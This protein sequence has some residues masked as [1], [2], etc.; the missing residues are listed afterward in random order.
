MQIQNPTLFDIAALPLIGPQGQI[1]F[2]VILKGTFLQSTGAPAEPQMRIAYGDELANETGAVRYESDIV[3]FKP[4]TDVVLW[5][6][7]YAP[8]GKPAPSVPVSAGIGAVENQLMVFGERYWNHT[9]LL[10]REYRITA[11]KPF[12]RQPIVYEAAFGGI[13]MLSGAYCAENL[14]GC[15]FHDPKGKQNLAG[16]PLPRIE[17][18]RHLIRAVSDHPR[19]V[20]F[21]FYHRACQPRAAFAGTYDE[22]WRK[23]RCPLPPA[24]FDARFYNGAHPDLQAVGY[25][26]GDEPVTLTHLTPDGLAQF[27]LPGITPICRIVRR[28]ENGRPEEKQGKMHLDTLFIE[29]DAKHYCIVWRTAIPIQSVPEEEIERVAIFIEKC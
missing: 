17:D 11:A 22:T 6:S 5:A 8:E 26:R 16:K 21:G 12:V 29:P 18:P 24:D 13:D 15:G 23:Q 27:T 28:N 2:T 3:P 25:L 20:G 1:L 10:R 19:P 14:V 4:R 7:A 9:G